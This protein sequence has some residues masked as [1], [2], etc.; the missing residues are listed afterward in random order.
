MIDVD[1]TPTQDGEYDDDEV[2]YVPGLRKIVLPQREDLEDTLRREDADEAE[3]EIVEGEV[4]HLRL[5]VVVQ[6]HGEHVEADEHHDDHVELL[7]GH[8]TEHYGLR[9]PLKTKQFSEGATTVQR[10][11]VAH[12]LSNGGRSKHANSIHL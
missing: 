2:E 10:I 8:D 5:P 6:G 12:Q 1:Y 4:P 11:L 7:V 9:P 3:V